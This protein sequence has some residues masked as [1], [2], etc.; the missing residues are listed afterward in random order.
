MSQHAIK[1]EA[2]AGRRPLLAVVWFVWMEAMWVA[3]FV[4]L[5]SD[6]LAEV[7]SAVMHLPAVAQVAV[8]IA[9]L[10]WMLGSWVWLGPWP[11]WIRGALVL[12]FA[13][14]WS[15]ISIPRRKKSAT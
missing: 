9:F 12:C 6:R 7:W 8:W 15:L 11:L 10:P 14:G 2:S 1:T 4:L 5:F 13:I 3:F